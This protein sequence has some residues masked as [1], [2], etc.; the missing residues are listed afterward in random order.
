MKVLEL[1]WNGDHYHLVIDLTDLDGDII[2][3]T[4]ELDNNYHI[5]T[6]YET[7]VKILENGKI[8]MGIEHDALV[9]VDISAVD[10]IKVPS[11]T[12]AER[13][14]VNEQTD[15]SQVDMDGVIRYN[16]ELERFEG[17]NGRHWI[18][19]SS[20]EDTDGDTKVLLE[21]RSGDDNDAIRFQLYDTSSNSTPIP[22]V[23]D[24]REFNLFNYETGEKT[25]I[26]DASNGNVT[27]TGDLKLGQGDALANMRVGAVDAG[28]NQ[29]FPGSTYTSALGQG[30]IVREPNFYSAVFGYINEIKGTQS[31]YL[32]GDNNKLTFSNTTTMIG[33][34]NNG[35]SMNNSFIGGN[36]NRAR[37][38]NTVIGWTGESI[39][40][41]NKYGGRNIWYFS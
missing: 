26:L 28:Q 37:R 4:Y 7:R 23:F 1:E 20:L 12:T 33:N 17:Y 25:I 6:N 9:A 14:F 18:S 32:F 40:E 27:I 10:G 19:L 39:I 41:D 29:L 34:G 36:D 13:P 22:Y 24:S 31:C 38:C 5:R 21:N 3:G 2:A 11:G 30:N 8:G 16:R 35:A 15:I